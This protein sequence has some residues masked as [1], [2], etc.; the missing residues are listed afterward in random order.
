MAKARKRAAG[1]AGEDYRH[2][3][4]DLPLR[5][6]VGTQ[7]QFRKK[8]KPKTYRFDPSLAPSFEWDGQNPARTMGEEARQ[9]DDK[10]DA[11]FCPTS[12]LPPC[13]M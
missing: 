2:L 8:K 6:E 5:P 9:V 4:S 3:T 12:A 1:K 11:M 10:P 13:E 7:A